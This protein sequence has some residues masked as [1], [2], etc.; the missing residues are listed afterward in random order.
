LCVLLANKSEMFL[1][2]QCTYWQYCISAG[3]HYVRIYL[4]C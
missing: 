2:T 3:L 4:M 1:E